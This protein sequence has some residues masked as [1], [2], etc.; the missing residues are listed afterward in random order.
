VD[1]ELFAQQWGPVKSALAATTMT[2]VL[3]A[4]GASFILFIKTFSRGLMDVLLGFTGGV[5]IAASFFS[6]LAP[7]LEMAK[8]MYPG[9]FWAPIALGF[10]GGS[11]FLF[12]LDKLLPHLHINFGEG[13]KEG[14]PT[15][16]HKTTLL[17]LAITLHNIPE[18]L[19]IGVLFGAASMGVEGASYGGAIALAIGIGLQNIPEGLAVAVPI[20]RMGVSRWKSLWYGQLSA[21]VEPI[22]GVVGAMAVVYIQPLLPFT[23]AFAAGAMIYIVIEEV[24]PETQRDQHTDF[25]V[26]SFISGFLLM[27]ILDTALL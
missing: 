27:M 23:M 6:L 18:G 8:S 25:A 12:A 16:W 15:Q 26:L 22:A 24:I 10:A 3:T 21:F 1:L 11:L 7:G 5:M 19:A 13:E 4:F 9:S 20:R 17:V 14:I 2:W